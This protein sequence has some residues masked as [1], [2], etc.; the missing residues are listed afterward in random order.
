MLNK[1]ELV[2]KSTEVTWD[3]NIEPAVLDKLN[4]LW[5]DM[6]NKVD[7]DTLNELQQ[8]YIVQYFQSSVIDAWTKHPKLLNYPN[9][10]FKIVVD[11][12]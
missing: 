5:L 4:T 11:T 2:M 10:T 1:K 8:D 7:F 12:Q 3:S 9:T 6:A